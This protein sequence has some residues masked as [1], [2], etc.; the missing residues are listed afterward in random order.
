MSMN[1]LLS[2]FIAR[3]RNAKLAGKRVTTVRKNKVVLNSTI[4]LT[5]LGYFNSYKDNDHEI[6]VELNLD[7]IHGLKRISKPGR[8]LFYSYQNLPVI[9]DGVGFNV[10]STSKGLKTN[11]DAKKE[12]VGGELIFQIW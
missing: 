12:M 9:K 2:D 10:L 6:E 8:R 3:L 5:K 4:L 11:I 1:D 7:K